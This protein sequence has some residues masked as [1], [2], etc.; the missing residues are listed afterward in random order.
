MR[1]HLSA[2]AVRPYI[3]IADE[4]YDG[5]ARLNVWGWPIVSLANW[6]GIVSAAVG[7]T[8]VWRG[9]RYRMDSLRKTTIFEKSAGP[10]EENIADARTTTRA[11]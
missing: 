9:I 6:L 10:R 5:V 3:A 7:R 4:D 11:A 2:R 8:I 1:A